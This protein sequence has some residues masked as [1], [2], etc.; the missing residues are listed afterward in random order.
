MKRLL[1]I[2]AGLF[3]FAVGLGIGREQTKD[4][5]AK[6]A[7]QK[8]QTDGYKSGNRVGYLAGYSDGLS[9]A[10]LTRNQEACEHIQEKLGHD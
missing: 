9:C 2:F 6:A 5:V 8:G 3:L 4:A 1:L 10:G 7:Y